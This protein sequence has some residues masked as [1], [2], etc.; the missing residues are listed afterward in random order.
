MSSLFFPVLLTTVVLAAGLAGTF[1]ASLNPSSSWIPIPVSS[2]SAPWV[3]LPPPIQCGDVMQPNNT[4]CIYLRNNCTDVVSMHLTLESIGPNNKWTVPPVKTFT[5][6]TWFSFP[7]LSLAA[8]GS[9]GFATFTANVFYNGTLENGDQHEFGFGCIFSSV[10]FDCSF[11]P[12]KHFDADPDMQVAQP[13][14]VGLLIFNKK[15]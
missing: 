3:P 12:G 9:K 8:N 14:Y 13:S 10:G 6:S 11:Q 4:L 2:S 7:S 1:S 15:K 5:N